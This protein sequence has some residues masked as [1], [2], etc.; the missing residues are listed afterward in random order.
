MEKRSKKP[1]TWKSKFWRKKRCMRN[2]HC[3][4]LYNAPKDY[5]KPFW[6]KDRMQTK[7]CMHRIMYSE[8]VIEA[9]CSVAFPFN[10]RHAATWDYW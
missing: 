7:S 3:T 10:H 4:W 9:E 8:D 2:G 1:W 5:C 6:A